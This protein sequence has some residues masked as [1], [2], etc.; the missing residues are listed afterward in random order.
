MK[1]EIAF[2]PYKI[3][4]DGSG[5]KIQTCEDYIRARLYIREKLKNNESPILVVK[6][7]GLNPWFKDLQWHA[8]FRSVSPQETLKNLIERRELPKILE[9]F[10][11]KI[12]DFN[13]INLAHTDPIRPGQSALDWILEV[14]IS[15]PWIRENLIERSDVAQVIEWFVNKRNTPIDNFL[16]QLCIDKFQIWK[17]RSVFRDL[18]QWLEPFPFERAYVFCLCQILQSYPDFL[19]AKWLQTDGQWNQFCQLPDNTKWLKE[20]RVM[21]DI[22][23]T[24]PLNVQIKEYLSARIDSEGLVIDVVKVLSGVLKVEEEIITSYLKKSG[25]KKSNLNREILQVLRDK[26]REG[27]LNEQLLRLEPIDRPTPLLIDSKFVDVLTWLK[28]YYFP[29]STWCR[30]VEREDLLEE[31]ALNFENWF[32]NNY[33]RLLS[34]QPGNFVCGVRKNVNPF[35][36]AGSSILLV[37]ADGLSF[38]WTEYVIKCFRAAGLYLEKDPEMILSMIPSISEVSKPFI[39]TGLDLSDS[40]QF[41]QLNLGYYNTLFREA[42]SGFVG[43]NVVATDSSD[44]LISLLREDSKVYLYL[45][46]EIDEIAHKHSNSDLRDSNIKRAI[47]SLASSIKLAIQNYESLHRNSL[48]AVVVGDH[49][50]LPLPREVKTVEVDE[51]IESSH[52][53]VV[54]GHEIEGCHLIELNGE[55]H[56]FVKGFSLIGKKTRGCVHGGL[57]PEELVVPFVVFSSTPPTPVQSPSLSIQGEIRRGYGECE[58]KIEITNPNPYQLRI[59]VVEVD[60]LEISESLPVEVSAKSTR[61]LHGI[62]NASNIHDQQVILHYQIQSVYLGQS[63]NDRGKIALK[64]TG[65]ALSD[66]SF[67][68]EFDV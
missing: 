65:A 40:L 52:G 8:T 48:K 34:E 16:L 57:T 53:R 55:I 59:E 66:E 19:K 11:Q 63:K 64:T 56:S 23:L 36:V 38:Q 26:F 41:K 18:L 15:F 7:R 12:V 62:L 24:P 39:I 49:G 5:F 44:S 32:I 9:Q 21:C 47:D 13:L 45:F 51:S 22:Q 33:G 2:D 17:N 43:K 31:T 6:N 30:A 1:I 27:G 54:R 20:I 35:I 4:T 10:P 37:I 68:R 67:E 29:Y 46:N 28:E 50:Y 14:T 61:E 42:Y 60:F 58:F 25:K 3:D